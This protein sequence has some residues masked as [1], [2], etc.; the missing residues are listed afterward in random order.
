MFKELK[1]Q[2]SWFLLLFSTKTAKKRVFSWIRR[3]LKISSNFGEI[4]PE[5]WFSE[6][7]WVGNHLQTLWNQKLIYFLLDSDIMW[8]TTCFVIME[9]TPKMIFKINF[10]IAYGRK[11][12]LGYVLQIW[13]IPCGGQKVPKMAFLHLQVDLCKNWMCY[14]KITF[15]LGISAI[16]LVCKRIWVDVQNFC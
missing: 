10:S 11:H 3:N 8:K 16:K 5:F 1:I 14:P 9:I 7:K 12:I 2:K 13:Y 6:P 4:D 15:K